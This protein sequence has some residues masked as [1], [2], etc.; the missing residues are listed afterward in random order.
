MRSLLLTL[1]TTLG[2]AL[3]PLPA[4]AH[5]GSAAAGGAAVGEYVALGDSYASGV[6]AGSYERGS[7]ACRRSRNAYPHLVTHALSPRV[8]RFV[9]C[10]G[11]TTSD[12][13]GGQLDALTGSTALVTITVGGNDLDFTGLMTTCVLSGDSACAKRAE[14]A[15][16]LVRNELPARLG[17]LYQQIRNRAPNA[18]VLAVGYPRLFEQASCGGGLTAAKRTALNAGA[19]LLAETTAAAARTSGV[20]F[21]DVRSRFAGHGICGSPRWVNPLVSPTS[22]SFHANAA[23]HAGGYAPAVLAAQGT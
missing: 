21:V 2:L 9:A 15:S 7:G 1:L 3:G 11:A 13:L 14:R 16:E 22:D 5:T 10:S 17:Q 12:V 23:G 4:V 6:G 19:D 20:V 18:R 8:M